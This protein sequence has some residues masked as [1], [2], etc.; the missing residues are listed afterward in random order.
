MSNLRKALERIVGLDAIPL[1]KHDGE[2]LDVTAAKLLYDRWS[3]ILNIARTALA[4]PQPDPVAEIV[5]WLRG[6]EPVID[7]PFMR[8]AVADEISRRF[9]S[10]P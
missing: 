7:W 5:A 4:E 3:E 1:P 8:A 9:G 6:L 10:K 2:S